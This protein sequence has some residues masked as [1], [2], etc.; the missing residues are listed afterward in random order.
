MKFDNLNDTNDSGS[1]KS[2]A[3]KSFFNNLLSATSTI[4]LMLCSQV[5]V[6][7]DKMPGR[8]YPNFGSNGVKQLCPGEHLSEL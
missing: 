6:V 8:N 2:Q 5:A 3:E 1:K 4:R 7:D